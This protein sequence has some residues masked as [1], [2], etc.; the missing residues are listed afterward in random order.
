MKQS[1]RFQRFMPSKKITIYM[2]ISEQNAYGSLVVKNFSVTLASEDD[3]DNQDAIEFVLEM[4]EIQF[5]NVT[6]AMDD[7]NRDSVSV[8]QLKARILECT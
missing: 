2:N 7:H 8:M 6:I 4:V 3:K 5:L 1:R